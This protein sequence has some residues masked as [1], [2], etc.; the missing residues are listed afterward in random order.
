[1]TEHAHGDA[2][3]VLR[4]HV[5]PAG[6]EGL[7]FACEGEANGRTRRS[8]ESN[9]RLQVTEALVFRPTRGVDQLDDVA[10][11]FFVHVDFANE[12][13]RLQQL[14]GVDHGLNA[15][16]GAGGHLCPQDLLL[17]LRSGVVEDDLEQEAVH[18]R[19]REGV[20]AFLFHRVL[21]GEHQKRLGEWEGFRTNGHLSLLHRF[22]QRALDFGRCPVDF[23]GQDKVGENGAFAHGEG[24]F[25]LIVDHGAY[26]IRRQEVRGELNAAEIHIHRLAEGLDGQRL[27]QSR[28]AFEE[29]MSIGKQADEQVVDHAFLADDAFA[30]LVT[31][32]VDEPAGRCYAVGQG[33][34]VRVAFGRGVCNGG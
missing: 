19:F 20:G 7:G 5:T 14:L 1:M 12:F 30:H 15:G 32:W 18:L 24:L 21:G 4:N 31:E 16:Q 25:F 28:H 8:A 13:P 3:D 26:H 33:L 34:N 9:E 23:I 17:F 10:F 29:D 6:H 11:Y 2:S 22:E 27:G